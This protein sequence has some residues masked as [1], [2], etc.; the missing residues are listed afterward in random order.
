[1]IDFEIIQTAFSNM[2]A[3]AIDYIPRLAT[4]LIILLAGWM[5]AKFVATVVQRLGEKLRLESLLERTGVKAGL[6]KAQISRSGS[7][8]LGK[9]L[10]WMIFLNFILIAL[11]SL[12][13]NAAVEPLR[14]LIAFLPRLLAAFITLTAGVLLAQFLG[15]AAQAAMSGMGV[16]FH[17]E[18]GQGVNV[19]LI[20]MIVIVVLEQLGINASIMTNIFT[21]VI[22]IIVAGVALAF[23]LGGRDVARNVLAGYYAREQFEMGDLLIINGEEGILEAIGT[24]NS[25]I[26]IGSERLIVPNTALTDTAVKVKD[27]DWDQPILELDE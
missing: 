9:L 7:E 15:K 25:E 18:V 8:L 14:N 1:M 4:A 27:S 13:L 10:Y 21:N 20:I 17:Q 22:T 12:G 24:L 2:V 26:R 3:N 19:L 5:L 11:E 23:G 6:E 16:E